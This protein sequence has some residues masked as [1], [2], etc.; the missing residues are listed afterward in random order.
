MTVAYD[1]GSV[2]EEGQAYVMLSRVQEL[3][4]VYFVDNFNPEKLYPSQKA[5][6]EL[7]RMNKV[8][9]NKNP[10]PWGKPDA[11]ALKIVSLNS[12]GH[13]L[14]ISNAMID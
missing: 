9:W 8:S 7:E 13:T 6:A 10:G 5:L 12:A 2:F 14:E 1:I 4:Q 3:K 11:D